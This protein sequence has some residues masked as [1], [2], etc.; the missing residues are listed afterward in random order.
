MSHL[1]INGNKKL[2]GEISVHGAKNSALPILAASVVVGEECTILN[3]P[4]LSDIRATVKILD[5][6]GCFKST[7]GTTVTVNSSGLTE[8]EIPDCLMR[9]LRSSFIFMGAL[10]SKTGRAVMCAPGG[11]EIGLRPVDIHLLAFEQ[12]GA[13]VK[14]DSGKIICEAPNG[15]HGAEITL[16]F[17][18][19]GAT[20][21]IMLA[22]VKAKGTTYIKN[23]AREP[24]IKDLADF[25]N[26]CGA[27]IKGAGESTIV[28][29][30][31]NELYSAQY[32]VMPDRIVTV[33]YLAAAAVT[34]SELL[35]KNA[36]AEHISTVISAFEQAG[37]KF[38]ISRNEIYIS[39]PD[40]LRKMG[41]VR[42]MPYPGF[43]TDCQAIVMAMAAKSRGTTIFNENIFESR[44]RHVGELNRMGAQI[45][46]T[47]RS[48]IVNGVK[49]LYGC[50]MKATDLRGGM[51]L[52]IAALGAH[53]ES[54][55]DYVEYIDR[56]YEKIE[57]D[58]SLIGADIRRETNGKADTGR[59][60]KNVT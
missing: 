58:L 24:E 46:V 48:A 36:V 37:C 16:S 28:I 38:K 43:P 9:E 3:C 47:G 19:V 57:R 56:G 8:N 18:S 44:F 2:G 13:V 51:A 53:G 41:T 27:D 7:D 11:C 12:M 40:R 15:L 42:T 14:E 6:L 5:Y 31:K 35:V 34:G 54:L 52:V 50:N 22:A 55:I 32:Y 60:R 59:I 23:A 26:A 1:I 4:Q 29:N 45:T 49:N 21:N 10:V 25:L 30:G 39:S 20:E 17:P 33:S